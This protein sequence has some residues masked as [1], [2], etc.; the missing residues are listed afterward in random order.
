MNVEKKV[1]AAAKQAVEDV[2][3]IEEYLNSLT[4]QE[5]ANFVTLLGIPSAKDVLQ[6]CPNAKMK[7][8]GLLIL[9]LEMQD[10]L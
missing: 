9:R 7:R 10:L 5:R 2:R 4:P 1:A 3:K 8:V 6:R